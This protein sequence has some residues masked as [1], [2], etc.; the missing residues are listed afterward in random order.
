M[1]DARADRRRWK[2]IDRKLAAQLRARDRLTLRG[3]RGALRTAKADRREKVKAVRALCRSE[4]RRLRDEAREARR[5]LRQLEQ[6][7]RAQLRDRTGRLKLEQATECQDSRAAAELAGGAGIQAAELALEHERTRQKDDRAFGR[8]YKRVTGNRAGSMSARERVEHSDDEVRAN[9]PPELLG[10]F[11]KVRGKIKSDARRSRTEV[12]LEYV[13]D[14]PHVIIEHMLED[15]EQNARALE[16]QEREL[17]REMKKP[18]RYKGKR[19]R[20][21]LAEY[22]DDFGGEPIADARASGEAPF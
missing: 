10:V 12:F 6:E 11:D 20:A 4:R 8:A 19:A 9:L 1:K 13:H 2:E 17:A 18:G 7:R 16:R 21:A 14:H 5:E 3:L 22:G 15:A